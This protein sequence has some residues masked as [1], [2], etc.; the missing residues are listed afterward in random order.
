MGKPAARLGDTCAHGGTI[1]VGFPMVLIGGMP[2]ARVGDMH[3]CPMLNPGVPPPPHVGGPIAMG[4]PMVLIGGM[5]AARMGDMAVCAGPPDTILMGCPT[6]LIGEGGAGSSSGGG[7]GSSGAAG[8]NAGAKTAMTDNFESSTKEEHWLEFEFVD[9]AGNPISGINYKLKDTEG[10]ESQGFLRN[11]G[12]VLRDALPEGESK[13]EIQS[14]YNAKWSKESAK[15]GEKIELTV[16]SDGIKDGETILFTIWKR[17]ISG[18]ESPLET[19]EQK[20]NGNKSKAEWEYGS[21]KKDSEGDSD[22]DKKPPAG[23][24]SPEYYFIVLY[25]PNIRTRSGFLY[26]ED[27]MEIELK[28]EENNPLANEE[29]I[30]FAPNG[31]VRNGKLDSKGFAKEEKLPGGICS[32]RFPNLPKFKE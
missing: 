6:V 3:V 28:D 7:A 21:S 14:L 31:E 25:G 32:V 17:D 22:S 2:A 16:E 13:V 1:V 9:K 29:Y 8:A 4:S 18:P 12:R 23:F 30:I 15:V 19:I 20:V 26:L 27:Y 10:K 24:S 11:D 5:P